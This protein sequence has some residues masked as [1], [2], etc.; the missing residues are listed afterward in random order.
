[1]TQVT[2]YKHWVVSAR[3]D[4]FLYQIVYSNSGYFLQIFDYV[5]AEVMAS[6]AL[7]AGLATMYTTVKLL[8]SYSEDYVAVYSSG[9][10][11]LF[12]SSN[13]Q[14]CAI[15]N[16]TIH[17]SALTTLPSDNTIIAK[18]EANAIVYL[19]SMDTATILDSMGIAD[20]NYIK[21][22]YVR[23]YEE[24][25]YVI[26]TDHTTWYSYELEMSDQSSQQSLVNGYVILMSAILG[27][28]MIVA[29]IYLLCKRNT[30][31][32]LQRPPPSP[33]PF[34]P[35]SANRMNVNRAVAY[36]VPPPRTMETHVGTDLNESQASVAHNRDTVF[37]KLLACPLTGLLVKDPVVATDGY[38]YEREA[39]EQWFQQNDVSP[40]T[41]QPVTNK[42]LI[43][44]KAVANY[45]SHASDPAT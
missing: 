19:I 36:H 13:G 37:R 27:V 44:N 26:L 21:F 41:Q 45:I 23:Q 24:K 11:M 5:R 7:P 2:I 34:A 10:L 16:I 20:N 1:M 9:S 25:T 42:T 39:I 38:T 4:T 40:V 22:I 6:V 8:V 31:S 35:E 28:G 17:L 43:P 12:R 3:R 29:I 18:D 14:L 30:V 15:A 32:E 33:Q